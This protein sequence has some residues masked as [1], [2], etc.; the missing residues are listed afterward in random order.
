MPF[1]LEPGVESLRKGKTREKRITMEEQRKYQHAFANC[2]KQAAKTFL[3][4]GPEYVS[5]SMVE[6]YV[7]LTITNFMTKTEL[8]ATKRDSS[9]D[10]ILRQA[11][12]E[13]DVLLMDEMRDDLNCMLKEMIGAQLIGHFVDLVPKDDFAIWIFLTDTAVVVE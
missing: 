11:R 3:S 7:V 1:Y 5:A 8:F 6:N 10:E 13:Y 9:R 2:A 12:L 4:K